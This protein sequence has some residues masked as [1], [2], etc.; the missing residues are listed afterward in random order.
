MELF[1]LV[2]ISLLLNKNLASNK[3]EYTLKFSKPGAFERQ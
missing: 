2:K 1:P 3:N